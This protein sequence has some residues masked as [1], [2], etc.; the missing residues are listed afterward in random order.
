MKTPRI[1]A[2]DPLFSKDDVKK[3]L[4]NRVA[5]IKF[6]VYCASE[7]LDRYEHVEHDSKVRHLVGTINVW[8]ASP[9]QENAETVD[10]EL[11]S[12]SLVNQIIAIA[13]KMRDEESED[14]KDESRAWLALIATLLVAEAVTMR[15]YSA[16][17]L[18]AASTVRKI[19]AEELVD[20]QLA[21]LRKIAA[22]KVT[23]PEAI[24][25]G[26]NDPEILSLLVK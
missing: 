16:N 18:K 9:T 22:E 12:D 4:T 8:V 6:G 19:L 11:R 3:C 21:T 10:Q 5:A 15:R 14:Q 7:V 24:P 23:R 20:R 1:P 13:K 17:I 25:R 26:V 2:A